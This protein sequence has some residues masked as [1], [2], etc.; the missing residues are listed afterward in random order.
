MGYGTGQVYANGS[1]VTF[2]VGVGDLTTPTSTQKY[3]LGTTVVLEDT[4]NKLLNK[5][6]YVKAGAG[7]TAKAIYFINPSNVANA[8]LITATPATSA[9]AKSYGVANTAFTNGYYGYLQTEGVTTVVSTG[10]ATIGNTGKMANGVLTVTDEAGTAETALTVGV[11]KTGSV[12]SA[13][14]TIYLLPNKKATV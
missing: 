7:L 11:F 5:Y 8:E 10:A 1:S 12:G 4:Q 3:P 9:F 2:S 6:V 14:N 13:D